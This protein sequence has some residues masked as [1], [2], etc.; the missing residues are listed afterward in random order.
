MAAFTRGTSR[1]CDKTSIN[2]WRAMRRRMAARRSHFGAGRPSSSSQ[3]SIC[4]SET[5]GRFQSAASLV[6]QI[7]QAMLRIDFHAAIGFLAKR[8]DRPGDASGS[9]SSAVARCSLAAIHCRRSNAPGAD[10]IGIIVQLANQALEFF[11]GHRLR[12]LALG[13]RQSG[14]P[15]RDPP[16][17]F[18]RQ[19]RL[20]DKLLELLC[21]HGCHF[22][23]AKPMLQPLRRPGGGS[24]SRGCPV[25]GSVAE[26]RRVARPDARP[27]TADSPRKAPA[28]AAARHEIIAPKMGIRG[29][30]FS[31]ALVSLGNFRCPHKIAGRPG[32]LPLSQPDIFV[33]RTCKESA[34]FQKNH[35]GCNDAPPFSRP[36]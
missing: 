1:S 3:S 20:H 13:H 16:A 34:T 14:P 24:R 12:R 32:G 15:D 6:S 29:K 7:P 23:H 5:G 8:R 9:A 2:S 30:N 26:I 4:A 25:P 21:Q 28:S 36:P 19:L 33:I 31:M 11:R 17:D 18:E 22:G 10:R 35:G 27:R